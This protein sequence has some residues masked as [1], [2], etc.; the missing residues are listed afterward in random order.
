MLAQLSGSV[1]CYLF[2]VTSVKAQFTRRNKV[3]CFLSL[4]VVCAFVLWCGWLW[5]GNGEKGDEGRKQNRGVQMFERPYKHGMSRH[6]NPV[7][8]FWSQLLLSLSFSGRNAPT[9]KG[10]LDQPEN[11]TSTVLC[12][13]SSFPLPTPQLTSHITMITSPTIPS[14]QLSHSLSQPHDPTSTKI[15]QP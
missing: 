6:K 4:V 5:G 8:F 12:N 14:S 15:E 3:E 7:P 11:L 1:A 13:H 9:K 2:A 10:V